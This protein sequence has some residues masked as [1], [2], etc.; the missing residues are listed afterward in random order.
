MPFT[1]RSGEIAMKRILFGL[2]AYAAVAA[3]ILSQPGEKAPPGEKG[4]EVLTRGPIHEAFAEPSAA[5]RRPNPVIH[6]QPPAAIEELP[7]DQKPDGAHIQWIPGYFAWDETGDDYIWVS[8]LWRATPPGRQW[9][10][11]RWASAPDGWQWVSGYWATEGQAEIEY[12]PPPPPSIDTGPTADAPDADSL[13]I[14]GTWVYQ[15]RRYLWRPGFWLRANADWCYTPARYTDTPAGYLFTD[16]YWD[17]PLDRRGMLFA[18]VRFSATVW[19]T[20]GWSY[21]PRYAMG[22][23]GL[24]DSLFVRPEFNRYYFGDY[25]GPESA[26]QGF[27]PW[28]DH[29]PGAK[30]PDPLFSHT[31]WNARGDVMWEESL[32]GLHKDR[33]AGTAARPPVTLARQTEFV[34]NVTVNR[35]VQI[36]NKSIDVVDPQGV[37][38]RMPLMATL[39]KADHK[40]FKLKPVAPAAAVEGRKAVRQTAVVAQERQA[41]EAKIVSGGTHPVKPADLSIRAKIERPQETAPA[42]VVHVP[43]PSAPAL[44]KHAEQPIPRYE[45]AKP[46]HVKPPLPKGKNP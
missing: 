8:G 14:P 4:V 22:S 16:G 15:E 5:D 3:P 42:R 6:Q 44:P 27:V 32:R 39:D 35:K 20:P 36:G 30:I 31:R 34:H 46:V 25:Y 18:P 2:L 45:P 21:Q 37:L 38:K 28:F 23:R 40:E 12:L 17:F 13:Y 7:P 41:R 1:T 9:T 24:L 10:P 26:R 29:R 43:G 33:L 19:T 11:G